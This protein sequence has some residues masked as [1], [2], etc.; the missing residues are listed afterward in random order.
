R[1]QTPFLVGA[2]N[3]QPLH[4]SHLNCLSQGQVFR[5][6]ALCDWTSGDVTA[7]CAPTPPTQWFC[8]PGLWPRQPGEGGGRGGEVDS[9]SYKAFLCPWELVRTACQSLC[10]RSSDAMGTRY[11]LVLFLILLVLGFE[12]QGNPVTPQD[13]ATSLT[14]LSKMQESLFS[15]W[16]TAKT[17]AENLYKKTYLPSM[18]E[19]IRDMYSK[20]TAAVSTYAGI[21]T[22]QVLHLLKGEE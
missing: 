8:W 2:Q 16:D 4:S 22:D 20:S 21:F 13:E 14:L 11:L 5:V 10:S 18:D 15:Y 1:P 19:K 7:L 12:V 3:P 17:A 9:R 6:G